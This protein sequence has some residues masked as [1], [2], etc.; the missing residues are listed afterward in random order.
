VGFLITVLSQILVQYANERTLKID[1]YLVRKDTVIDLSLVRFFW[2]VIYFLKIFG[3][4]YS[5][6]VKHLYKLCLILYGSWVSVISQGV[7]C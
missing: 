5:D 4:I 6:T 3:V 1:H 2:L 7:P